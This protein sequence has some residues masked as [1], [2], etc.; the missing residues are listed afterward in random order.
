M[1][2]LSQGKPKEASA[3][4]SNGTSSI[5]RPFHTQAIDVLEKGLQASPSTF[6]V[7][8][9]LLFNLCKFDLQIH[10]VFVLIEIS[11]AV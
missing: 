2:L 3:K 7:T 5:D 10:N 8:E 1:S 6:A 9:P 4:N 11:N